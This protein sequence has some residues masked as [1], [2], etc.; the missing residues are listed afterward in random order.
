MNLNMI[1]PKTETEDLLLSI[2][3]NCQ[4]LIEQ[5][6]R[7][8]EETLDFKMI[9]SKETFHFEPSIQIEGNWM[10]G[11]IDLEVY[12]SIFNITE[13]NNKFELYVDTRRIFISRINRRT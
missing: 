7:K 2:T 10:L 12:N 4:T 3:K 5:T 13:E 1:R 6:H 8:A 9:K 11:F